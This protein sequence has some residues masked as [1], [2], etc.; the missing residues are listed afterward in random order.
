MKAPSSSQCTFC[1]DTIG[2]GERLHRGVQ[3]GV[4]RADRRRRRRHPRAV[5]NAAQKARV[6]SCG[7]VHLPVAGDQH[8]SILCGGDRGHAGQ[9]LAL[10]QLERGA[11]ARRDPATRSA[12]PSLFDR[13]HRVAAADDRVRVRVRRPRRRSRSSPRRSAATRRR[14]SGRSR[15]S[16]SPPRSAR[17][18]RSRVSGPMSS[19]SQPSGTSSAATTRDSASASNAAAATTS[20]GSSTSHVDRVLVAD[21]LGH[22]A[23][24]EHDDPPLGR[25]A[26]GRRSC[27]RPSRRRRSST[28]GGPTSPSSRAELLELA[29]E[30]EAG[31]RGQAARA[32]PS[33]EACARW[34]EPK[35][36]FT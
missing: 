30:Q 5:A 25:A 18:N 3:R 12:R 1:G 2:P 6:S 22:L 4:R 14:P 10:E 26:A 11:A 13:P 29:L 8:G 7:L 20:V 17:Q 27:P 23:A 28:N 33:V 21:L 9:L 24:D 15:R 31:V 16:S 35:A 36:S 19:P 32:T 34:A